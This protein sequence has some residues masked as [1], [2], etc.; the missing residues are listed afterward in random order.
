MKGLTLQNAEKFNL[1]KLIPWFLLFIFITC[2]ATTSN[3]VSFSWL[4]NDDFHPT[5]FDENLQLDQKPEYPQVPAVEE[6][7]SESNGKTGLKHIVFGIAGSAKLW[8]QR[9]NYIKLWWRAQ[10]MRGFVWLDKQVKIHANDTEALPTLKISGDTSRFLYTN[11]KGHRSGIRI[12]RILSETVRLGL[13]DVRWFVMGDDDTVFVADNLVRVL[14]KYDHNQFYY[15][16][17]VSE[18]H[19]QNI[20]FSYGMAYGG[21]GFAISYALAKEIEKMQDRCIQRYPELYGSDDRMQACMAEIGV[22]LTKMPGFHQF[23]VYGNV[24]GLL[25][26]H[27]VAPLV[28]LHHLD[29]IDPI[30]PNMTRLEALQH[31]NI[32]TKFD[33]AGL[34]QQSICY[35]KNRFWTISSSWG[36]AVQIYRGYVS[37][38]ELERPAR[39]FLSW[40]R[41]ADDN[42]FPFNTRPSSRNDCQVPFT[43]YLSKAWFDSSK[44]QIVSEY[45]RHWVRTPTCK[46]KIP[47]P[48]LVDTVVVYKTPDPLL[49]DKAPRRNCCRVLPSNV[50]GTLLLNVGVCRQ[51]E[52][53][54]V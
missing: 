33:S 32:P 14:E 11:K 39:T 13:K 24:M 16:G 30:F 51:G 1:L 47:D 41:K 7:N 42:S 26:A 31:L 28:S 50:E 48:N 22:P 17:S 3:F 43:Y 20:G 10:E 52:I 34:M 37:A 29:I 9:K 23:D 35:N 45:V 44:N 19:T 21:G 15:I 4:L 18:S 5:S 12:S 8:E 53:G 36:Y 46:W 49:W 2:L 40:Y 27:P 6:E 38:R 54:E 25:T